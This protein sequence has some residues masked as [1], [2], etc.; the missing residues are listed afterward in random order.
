MNKSPCC[1]SELRGYNSKEYPYD[2]G[3]K[4]TCCGAE[5][6]YLQIARG[7]L[8]KKCKPWALCRGHHKK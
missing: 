1:N 3:Y 8:E 5:F 7:A 6:S 4:C 2:N